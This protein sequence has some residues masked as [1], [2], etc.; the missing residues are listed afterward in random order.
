MDLK[1]GDMVQLTLIM[2]QTIYQINP[3]YKSRDLINV[4]TYR[5]LKCD[6]PK[7]GRHSTTHLENDSDQ[8]SNQTGTCLEIIDKN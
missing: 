4:L 7:K 2:L 3:T 8:I 6:G 5:N 1:R